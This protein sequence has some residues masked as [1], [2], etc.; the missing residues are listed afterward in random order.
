MHPVK[1]QPNSMINK[2]NWN[3]YNIFK[4]YYSNV[5]NVTLIDPKKCG[6]F[7]F[8]TENEL[9]NFLISSFSYVYVNMIVSLFS[10]CIPFNSVKDHNDTNL[11]F[12]VKLDPDIL[13]ANL[14][15]FKLIV[16]T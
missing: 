13:S 15:N 7:T 16:E 2:V 3:N 11:T 6:I 8:M 5:M 9:E 14:D 1:Y 10:I 12:N 4:A